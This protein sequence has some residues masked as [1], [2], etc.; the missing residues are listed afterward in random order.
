VLLIPAVWY[1]FPLIMLASSAG[2]KM[3][4]KDVFEAAAIDGA[5]VWQTF[6]FITIPLLRPLL[7]PA[8]IIRAIFAFNQ[9]YLLWAFQF[10]KGD[11]N[12]LALLSYD[13][14]NPTFGGQFSASAIVNIFTVIILIGFVILF[15]REARSKEEMKNA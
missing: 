11:A 1:G 3:I 8:I 10:W 9:F 15:N 6:R 14:F 7:L 5:T 13:L 4:P 12:T 2:L